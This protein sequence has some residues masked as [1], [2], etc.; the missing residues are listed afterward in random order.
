L[1]TEIEKTLRKAMK[2]ERESELGSDGDA[3]KEEQ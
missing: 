3:P 2:K 1:K